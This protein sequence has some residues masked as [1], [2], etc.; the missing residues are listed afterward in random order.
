MRS[1]LLLFFT[2]ALAAQEITAVR[3]S[4]PI[5]KR[6]SSGYY[7]VL[8]TTSTEALLTTPGAFQTRF[9][10]GTCIV[11]FRFPTPGPCDDLYLRKFDKDASTLLAAT[12]IGGTGAEGASLLAVD[13][14]GV[15]I[16]GSSSSPDFAGENPQ[17]K[18]TSVL[19]RLSADLTSL[20]RFERF[21]NQIAVV[22][23]ALAKAGL[24]L[25]AYNFVEKRDPQTLALNWRQDNDT[26]L[27]RVSLAT[28]ENGDLLVAASKSLHRLRGG[29]GETLFRLS[30]PG[31]IEV[32]TLP[33]APNRILVFG[34]NNDKP[35]YR[36][37]YA[38][39][40]DQGANLEPNR[41]LGRRIDAALI[42]DAKLILFGDA[43][44]GLDTTPD[45][46]IRCFGNFAPAFIARLDALSLQPKFVTYTGL[47]QA[48]RV[49][50]FNP[51][52]LLIIEADRVH[53]LA[54]PTPVPPASALCLEQSA[55]SYAATS[56]RLNLIG[57]ESPTFG[58]VVPGD[59]LTFFGAGINAEPIRFEPDRTGFL[60]TQHQG[61][62]FLADGQPLG[63]LEIG[64][65]SISVA[66]PYNLG[67]QVNLTLEREGR[68]SNPI[69]LRTAALSPLPLGISGRSRF[70]FDAVFRGGE[71]AGPSNPVRPG[72]EITIYFSGTGALDRDV[73]PFL[74]LKSLPL[75]KPIVPISARLFQS[76]LQ[77]L[78]YAGSMLGQLPGVLQVNIRISRNQTDFGPQLISVKFGEVEVDLPIFLAP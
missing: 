45:A 52:E 12:Y 36:G 2:S 62:R 61:L 25:A 46:P 67:P 65:N 16:F 32:R 29:D 44:R 31:A 51:N 66:F 28:L 24:F 15:Y 47:S 21:P 8:Q 63:I 48:A 3:G 77:E 35:L 60:P 38:V 26:V 39:Y 34:A 43:F 11:G 72:D 1:W 68:L 49:L 41:F 22:D 37:F 78:L 30:L 55:A 20:Q 76:G 64:S 27:D 9:G 56:G 33:L 73:D 53:S 4:Q 40:D 74:T 70:L 10:G 69:R 54:L 17:S 14:T 13:G 6:D 75:P 42:Q 7:Y 50:N 19:L 23:I 57:G 59:F 71:L 58:A 5:V 18:L